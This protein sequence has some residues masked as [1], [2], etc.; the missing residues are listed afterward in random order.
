MS[1][2]AVLRELMRRDVPK[3]PAQVIEDENQLNA[4]DDAAALHDLRLALAYRF[5]FQPLTQADI[6][7]AAT[8]HEVADLL[9]R[10]LAARRVA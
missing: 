4:Y 2:G 7:P 1:I 6:P 3:P 5:D 9:A 10:K 8:V